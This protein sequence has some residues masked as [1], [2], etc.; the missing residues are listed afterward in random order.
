MKSCLLWS[1]G[2][3][4]FLA[5]LSATARDAEPRYKFTAGETNV[6]AVEISVNSESGSELTSGNVILRTKKVSTNSATLACRGNMKLEF[7]RA[8]Q[9]GP[10]GFNY[11]PGNSMQY[12]YFPDGAEVTFD[13]Q[14]NEIRDSGDY[15][16]PAPLGKLVQSLF[17]PLSG[18]KDD[19][20]IVAVLDEPFWLGPAESF[21][22][23]RMYG[24]PFQMNYYFVDGQRISP[25]ALKVVSR[26]S[27][28]G[29]ESSAEVSKWQRESKLESLLLAGSEPRFS[30]TSVASFSL[31]RHSGLP[32]CV[33]IQSDMKGLAPSTTRSAK[34]SFKAHLLTGDERAS[35]LNPPPPPPPKEIT[36]ADLE[37]LAAS[38]KSTELETRRAVIARL[39]G[40]DVG[41][42]SA[43]FLTLVAGMALDS[44]SFTHSTAASFVASHATTNEVPTLLKLL[45]DSDWSIRSAAVKALGRLK[46]ERAIVPLADL[47]ARGST[48]YGQDASSALMSIGAPAEKA[49]IAL[50]SERNIETE[51]QACNILQQIGTSDSLEPLQKF[52]GDSEQNVSQAAVDAI[53]AIKQRQ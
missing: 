14:G 8:Q 33:E 51:R 15:V 32:I 39:N 25:G 9:R 27:T 30:G 1:F 4:F 22:N 42:P 44:D 50:L 23:S 49:V 38:L 53:R 36:G 3:F 5:C 13:F 7:K 45:K 16:L 40:A 19:K 47:V 52:V 28:T 18:K 31:D 17:P 6:F 11:F 48:S 41:C 34:L 29:K 2:S 12:F 24:Q 46:D 43:E 10:G 26:S 35:V 37:K 21:L 20:E